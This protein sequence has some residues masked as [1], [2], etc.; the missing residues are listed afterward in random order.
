MQSVQRSAEDVTF[1]LS[2]TSA[3]FRWFPKLSKPLAPLNTALG[4]LHTGWSEITMVPYETVA[5]LISRSFVPWS[6]GN[7]KPAFSKAAVIFRR[8][9]VSALDTSLWSPWFEKRCVKLP[10]QHL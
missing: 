5:I 3:H 10:R 7:I 4:G 2:G 6:G 8:S 9:S 1:E